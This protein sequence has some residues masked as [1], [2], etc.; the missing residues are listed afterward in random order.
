MIGAPAEQATAISPTEIECPSVVQ[1]PAPRFMP[2]CEEE[3]C[4][5]L[6]MPNEEPEQLPMPRIDEDEN[7]G[8]DQGN[9]P[10]GCPRPC[11]G[12][13]GGHC[14]YSTLLPDSMP[15]TTQPI[16][17]AACPHTEKS[18]PDMPHGD[19]ESSEPEDLS[20]RRK[21]NIFHSHDCDEFCPRHADVDTMEYRSS[22][23]HLY[24]YGPGSL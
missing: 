14:P 11:S 4:E 10:C 17:P 2:Y 20:L 19:E 3:E 15:G 23:R 5:T 1:G 16:P 9:L 18:C 8:G 12:P 21:L 6:P 7:G 13:C 22:D 24:D